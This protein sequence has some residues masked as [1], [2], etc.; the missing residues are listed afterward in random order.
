MHSRAGIQLAHPACAVCTKETQAP[1]SHCFTRI[2]TVQSSGFYRWKEL[3]KKYLNKLT[4]WILKPVLTDIQFS[5]LESVPA[6]ER[7]YPETCQNNQEW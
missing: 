1:Q 7:C 2:L 5:L 6:G 3:A 4:V